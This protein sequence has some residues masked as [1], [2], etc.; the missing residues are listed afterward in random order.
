VLGTREKDNSLAAVQLTV[1]LKPNLPGI[2]LSTLFNSGF[3]SF[4]C[5]VLTKVASDR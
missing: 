2:T 1:D 4:F 3:R 5:F